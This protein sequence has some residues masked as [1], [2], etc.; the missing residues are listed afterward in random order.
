MDMYIQSPCCTPS[1]KITLKSKCIKPLFVNHTLI[2]LEHIKVFI[3]PPL[4]HLNSFIFPCRFPPQSGKLSPVTPN[5]YDFIEGPLSTFTSANPSYL[6]P[7]H[8]K[9]HC[10]VLLLVSSYSSFKHQKNIT[11]WNPST[12]TCSGILSLPSSAVF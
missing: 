3:L 11:P 9:S 2:R 5:I 4:L 6:C 1:K 8:H 10:Y 7:E 12:L